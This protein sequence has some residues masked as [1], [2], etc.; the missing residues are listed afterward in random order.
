MK[1]KSHTSA[2]PSHYNTEATNY[3][4]FN[5]ENSKIINQ[6]IED[7]L[8][9]HQVKTVLDL[10][11]GTGSQ[12]FWL[13]RRGFQI[14][15]TDINANM[16]KIAQNKSKQENVNIQFIK[17]DMRSIKVGQFDAVITIFNAIG[18]LTKDDFQ[19][20]IQ[21]IYNNLKPNG[22]YLFDIFNLRYLLTDNNIMKLTIDWLKADK[23]KKVREIQ[24]S[25]VDEDGVLASFTTAIEQYGSSQPKMSKTSQTLQIYTAKQLQDLL[26][27]CGFNILNQ[28]DVDGSPFIENKSERIMTIAQKI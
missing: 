2:K 13:A 17:G 28:C 4:A 9:Q 12:V 26:Q 8:K 21:N 5:E 14:V 7:I 19:I 25:T 23:E 11:C 15:G 1:Y 22:L 3:D 18:H 6:T 24:Y 27:Q 10:T 20:A 16:L